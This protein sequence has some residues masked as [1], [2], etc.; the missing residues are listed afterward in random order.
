M[1]NRNSTK[2]QIKIGTIVK[3]DKKYIARD[4]SIIYDY[5]NLIGIVVDQK[6]NHSVLVRWQGKGVYWRGSYL[7][8]ST[9]YVRDLELVQ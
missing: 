6:E 9:H 3:F 5:K 7:D 8:Q 2:P 4:I 1:N